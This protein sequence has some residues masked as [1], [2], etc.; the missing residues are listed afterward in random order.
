MTDVCSDRKLGSLHRDEVLVLPFA[1]LKCNP[2]KP[3]IPFVLVA[4]AKV[5]SLSSCQLYLVSTD[6]PSHQNKMLSN[7]VDTVTNDSHGNIMP[8]HTVH[9]QPCSIHLIASRLRFE[10][11]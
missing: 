6:Q 3:I 5:P 4:L 11:P 2:I 9:I 10:S 1:A 7:I 8:W